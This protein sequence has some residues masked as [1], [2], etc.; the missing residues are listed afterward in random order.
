[1]DNESKIQDSQDN[2]NIWIK[3]E[4]I[5]SG[6]Y[7]D[8]YKGFNKITGTSIAIKKIKVIKYN[9]GISPEVLK[10]VI[11]LRGLDHENIIR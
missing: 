8:V 9:Y 4:K 3:E 11:L 6:A 2:D 7:G 1:M 10:E 5:G